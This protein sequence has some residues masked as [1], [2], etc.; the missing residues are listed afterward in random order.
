VSALP[1]ASRALVSLARR[2][3]QAARGHLGAFASHPDWQVR[4][5][6]ARAAAILTE[7]ATLAGLASD[8]HDNV[9]EAA[10]E[11][12][13]AVRGHDADEVFVAALEKPAYQVVMAAARALAGTPDKARA[14]PAL[15]E[16]LATLTAEKRDTSRDPRS[17]ILTRLEEL[18]GASHT[19]ALRPY[20][21]DADPEIA[22]RAARLLSAWTGTEHK[23]VTSR[24]EPLPVPSQEELDGLPQGMRVVMADGR[25]FDVA[26]DTW[27]AT[28][29][30]RRVS[31]LA[32]Q[33]YYNGLTFHRIVPNF[34]IQG[35]SP[36]AN[37][38]IGDGP[39][40]RNECGP[41]SNLRYSIGISTRGRDTGDAQLY[42]NLVD[43]ERLDH[44]YPVFGEVVQGTAVID[45]I[46]DGDVIARIELLRGGQ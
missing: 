13:A 28:M 12:L 46:I 41:R 37:E 40:M 2:D 20:L 14:V 33:G 1:P 3:P 36:G 16:A 43:N 19:G 5:S 15:L 25:S 18:G 17:A 11:G 29:T 23:A 24:V 7:S 8:A 27:D 34:V 10:L 38:F 26:F 4:V 6:A 30:V 32:E 44:Q 31:R 45:A 35:G 21:G 9:R 22:A 39:F 42:V